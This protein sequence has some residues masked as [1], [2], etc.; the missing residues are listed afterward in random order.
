MIQS[1]N[2]LKLHNKAE[3]GELF[4]KTELH[5][6]CAH[7]KKGKS[8]KFCKCLLFGLVAKSIKLLQ[9]MSRKEHHA[10]LTRCVKYFVVS[11]DKMLFTQYLL[12]NG[13][14]CCYSVMFKHYYLIPLAD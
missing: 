1:K 12:E 10:V 4:V 7:P 8:I 9:T 13:R 6:Q 5:G 3:S 2:I 11:P 14:N